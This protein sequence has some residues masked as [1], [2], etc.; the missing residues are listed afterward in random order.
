MI[1][2]VFPV[3]VSNSKLALHSQPTVPP[4][5]MILT[6]VA[7][8]MMDC[9]VEEECVFFHVRGFKAVGNGDRKH[10]S[11]LDCNRQTQCRTFVQSVLSNI[12]LLCCF[13]TFLFSSP[14]TFFR[15]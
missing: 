7:T 12:V 5:K 15:L 3:I 4:V 2:C 8:M 1:R 13:F 6:K 14:S 10:I 9:V 11:P